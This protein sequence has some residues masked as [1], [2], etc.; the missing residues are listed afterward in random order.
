MKIHAKAQRRKDKRST[1][2]CVF[3]SLRE[4]YP[5]AISIVSAMLLACVAFA[6]DVTVTTLLSELNRP[7]GVA[8]R[9]GGTAARYELA[10]AESGAG[11]VVRWSNQRPKEVAVAI[12]GF[13]TATAANPWQQAGPLAL[14]FVDP[15]LVIVASSANEGGSCLH[16]FELPDDGRPLTVDDAIDRPLGAPAGEIA[17]YSLARTRANEFVADLVVTAVR[18]GSG[19]SQLFKSRLQAGV[20]GLL[21]PFWAGSRPGN[22]EMP[23]PLATSNSGRIVVGAAR[24]PGGESPC[25]LTFLNPIDASVELEMP[26][27]L[28]AVIALAYSPITGSLYAAVFGTAANDG[29]IYRIDDVSEPG[30]PACRAVKIAN[31]PHPTALAFA[32]DGALFV[33]TFGSTDNSGTLVVLTGN[34]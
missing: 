10:I 5:F 9:L 1:F 24:E 34:L 27:D 2:L 3:A 11:R 31:I 7:C 13:T 15:D 19:R 16:V 25:Q 18:D 21:R 8:A 28:K 22:S 33:T 6:D 23:L 29:G 4:F 26:L 14:L 30:Q 20:V 12:G 17:G 32:P